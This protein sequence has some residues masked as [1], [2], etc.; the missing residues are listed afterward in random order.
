M[1]LPLNSQRFCLVRLF[2]VTV[3]DQ[4]GTCLAG[5]DDEADQEADEE[6]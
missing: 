6:G 1:K 2:V 5:F 3:V 4:A